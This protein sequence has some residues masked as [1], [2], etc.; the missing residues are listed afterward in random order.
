[1][2]NN[3][4]SYLGGP[5]IQ[6]ILN[7]TKPVFPKSQEMLVWHGKPGKDHLLLLGSTAVAPQTNRSSTFPMG[8]CGYTLKRAALQ[9]F[10]KECLPIF[11]PNATNIR[12]DVF[13]GGCLASNGIHTVDTRDDEGTWRYLAMNSEQQ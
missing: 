3:L 6:E 9:F 5:D 13:V 2:V 11:S 7:G 10:A 4:R 1:M 12:E 8:G